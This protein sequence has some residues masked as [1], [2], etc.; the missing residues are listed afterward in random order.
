MTLEQEMIYGGSVGGSEMRTIISAEIVDTFKESGIEEKISA[1]I[2]KNAF[3]RKVC[4]KGYRF[5]LK[6]FGYRVWTME[7]FVDK[8]LS[9]LD[10]MSDEEMESFIYS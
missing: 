9:V 10:C 3:D 1:E 4:M 5:Y 6:Y 8:L 2:L 7:D